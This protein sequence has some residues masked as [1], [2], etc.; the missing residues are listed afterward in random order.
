M[1]K[2]TNKEMEG[3]VT[4]VASLMCNGLLRTQ[5]HELCKREWGVG[6][7]MAE[8]Y[9]AR[10][11]EMLKSEVSK[12]RADLVAGA[13][14]YYMGVI[15]TPGVETRDKLKA[16][17]R[18]DALLGLDMPSKSEVTTMAVIDPSQAESAYN[19]ALKAKLQY[20][21]AMAKKDAETKSEP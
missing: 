11:R 15:R 5:I 21:T 1:A 9:M 10:A 20:E 3:R 6:W 13:V 8:R 17:E 7:R 16:R 2:S 4:K 18:L 19:K 14:G 12:E